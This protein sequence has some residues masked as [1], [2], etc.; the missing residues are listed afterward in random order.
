MISNPYFPTCQVRVARFY[1]SLPPLLLPP[2]L[3]PPSFLRRTSLQALDGVPA[4]PPPQAPD[5][6][7]PRRA[8]TASSEAESSLPDLNHKE[9]PKTYQ[10]ECQN[11]MLDRMSEHIYFTDEMSETKTKP[12]SRSGSLEVK[13][14]VLGS[15]NPWGYEQVMTKGHWCPPRLRGRNDSLVEAVN[16]WH[17][18]ML[19]LGA[20]RGVA[21]K[22]AIDD[23]P[24]KHEL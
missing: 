24:S 4:G 23:R 5:Q 8:S 17:F 16:D 19:S 7:V 6:S 13:Y 2:S 9:S 12:L 10:I 15:P 1:V 21:L 11:R 3:L 22:T 18:A 14:V 20:S